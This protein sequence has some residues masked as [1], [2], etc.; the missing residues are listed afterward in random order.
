MAGTKKH[1]GFQSVA[2]AIARQQDIPLERAQR[3]LAART[4][5]AST[6]AKRANPRLKRVK[7]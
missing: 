3:I 5:E 6:A 4:R 1:P 7:G 2:R